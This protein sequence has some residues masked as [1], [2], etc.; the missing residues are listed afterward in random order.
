M[1]RLVPTFDPP[2]IYLIIFDG[3]VCQALEE[4]QKAL[5]ELDETIAKV[6]ADAEPAK[7][8]AGDARKA[9]EVQSRDLLYVTYLGALRFGPRG[10]YLFIPTLSP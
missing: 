2:G 4:E 8:A 1:I 5:K 6:S 10:I 7:K 9:H 3:F